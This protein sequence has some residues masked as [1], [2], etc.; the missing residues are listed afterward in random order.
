MNKL[1]LVSML[2]LLC[3]ANVNATRFLEDAI[4]KD[5]TETVNPLAEETVVDGK[6][7]QNPTVD[8][9]EKTDNKS[10]ESPKTQDNE[11]PIEDKKEPTTETK[12]VIPTVAEEKPEVKEE[13]EE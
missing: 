4:A 12:E 1:L 13:G 3:M 11:A 2:V 10:T 6:Q 8:E 7:E 9:Q 5:E